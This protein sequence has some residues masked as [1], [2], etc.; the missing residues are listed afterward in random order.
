MEIKLEDIIVIWHR[1]SLLSP[2]RYHI[3]IIFRYQITHFLTILI[4][5]CIYIWMKIF[6]RNLVFV[7]VCSQTQLFFVF[8]MRSH[9]QQHAPWTNCCLVTRSRSTLAQVNPCFLTA[10]SH[11]LNHNWLFI[12]KAMRHSS[13]D[14]FIRVTSAIDH[15]SSLENYSSIMVFQSSMGRI[16]GC[17]HRNDICS[18]SCRTS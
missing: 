1:C 8:Q 15:W 10:P 12:N 17:Y 3:A 6:P 13:E 16:K 14:S 2:W 11:Y 4:F 5:M 9:T 18:N 7:A